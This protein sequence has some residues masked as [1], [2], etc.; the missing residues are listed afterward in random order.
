MKFLCI[1]LQLVCEKLIQ[2]SET[3]WERLCINILITIGVIIICR[4]K[5]LSGILG[6]VK[7]TSFIVLVRNGC[8]VGC[9]WNC[10]LCVDETVGH[11]R[12]LRKWFW[13][14]YLCFFFS[15]FIGQCIDFE[16]HVLSGNSLL[17]SCGK[18]FDNC[19]ALPQTFTCC[20][21]KSQF[22]RL[23]WMTVWMMYHAFWFIVDDDVFY[24]TSCSKGR[25]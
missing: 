18:E 14:E 8:S 4:R 13:G 15:V 24:L 17:T 11:C 20:L 21:I 12:P 6:G 1:Y 9:L 2:I 3:L 5:F 23:N 22:L 19:R 16:W 25:L 7:V 10:C